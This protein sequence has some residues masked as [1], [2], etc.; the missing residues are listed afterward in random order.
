VAAKDITLTMA[1]PGDG[2]VVNGDAG[3]LARVLTNLLSNAVK[4]T[5]SGGQVRVTAETAGGWAVV[6]VADSGIGIPVADQEGLFTRF[7]RA[8]NATK[9]AIQG[10]GLGLAI[11]QTIVAAHG[12]EISFQS[13]EGEGTT[14]SMRLPLAELA[15]PDAPADHE[16]AHDAPSLHGASATWAGPVI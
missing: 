4:F 12:G 2:L 11:V 5:P 14:I 1:C 13:Q 10:T 15:A 16:A 7:F 8:S 6:S 9:R 3:Q